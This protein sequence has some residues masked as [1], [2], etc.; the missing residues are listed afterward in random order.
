M[1]LKLPFLL[2]RVF[3]VLTFG[4][5]LGVILFYANGYSFDF[6]NRIIRKTGLIQI[7]YEDPKAKVYLD[8]KLME[9]KLPFTISSV[10]SGTHEVSIE[11]EGYVKW[12]KD[13]GVNS[14]LITFLDGVFMLP[15][16]LS[17]VLKPVR[18]EDYQAWSV[19]M[20]TFATVGE[21]TVYVAGGSEIWKLN[22]RDQK[23]TLLNRFIHPVKII[24]TNVM[25]NG[26][27]SHL[28]YQVEGKYYLADYEWQNV[29]QISWGD[30]SFELEV[31]LDGRIYLLVKDE[32]TGAKSVYWLDLEN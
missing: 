12:Q 15:E 8:G 7:V 6:V 14:D 21:S 22:R 9:G 3:L 1:R 24:G 28:L 16:D 5:V 29:R 2:F 19:K 25:I 31:G 17:T 26:D 4:L 30:K 13:I 10:L 32:G 23:K 11:R 20:P 18:K 27:S